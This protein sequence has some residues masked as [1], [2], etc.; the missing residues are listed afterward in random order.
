[1]NKSILDFP[2][3]VREDIATICNNG[4]VLSADRCERIC[5]LLSINIKNLMVRLLPLAAAYSRPPISSYK[6]GA[7][8]LGYDSNQQKPNLYIGTNIE[9][10]TLYSSI[11]AEQSAISNAWSDGS[12]AIG[13]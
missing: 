9:F 10:Q 4:G 8:V 1:M 2:V 7:V 6:V 11:H 13:I 3:E 12:T 5:V